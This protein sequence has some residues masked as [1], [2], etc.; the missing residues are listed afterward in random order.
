A[1]Q[2]QI[3]TLP[4]MGSKTELAI[5][6]GLEMLKEM[7]GQV[8]LG[9]A[10]PL[11]LLLQQQILAIP[12]VEQ[13]E[14][15]GSVRRG[16]EMVGDVDLVV[17]VQPD[18]QVTAVMTRHPQVKKVLASEPDRLVLLTYLGVKIEIIMVKPEDF[19]ATLFYATGARAH[20]RRLL[21]L[22]AIRGLEPA[23]LGLTTANWLTAAAEVQ[24][25]LAGEESP[26]DAEP[27]QEG[28]QDYKTE[29]ANSRPLGLPAAPPECSCGRLDARLPGGLSEAEQEEAVF[30]KRLGLPYIVPELREDRGELA[31]ALR[32][33][34]PRLITLDD[35]RGDLHLHS[36]YSDGVDTIAALAAAARRRGYS[37][38]AITDHSRSL[39]IA[40][41]LSGEKI[42]RQR[43]EIDRLNERLEG[44]RVL[45]GIEVDIL[46]DGRLDY[47]DETLRQFDLVIASVHSAFRQPEEQMMARLEAAL[48]HPYVDILGHP[49]GRMLGRRQPYA[50]DV[51]RI[52]ELAAET[53]TI[54]E[55]NASPD[56]LDLN[57]VAV[58]LAKKRGVPIAIN[59]DAHDSRRLADMEYGLLTARRGWL[60]PQDVVNTW[61][62]KRLLARLKRNRKQ[63]GNK[64][65]AKLE[66]A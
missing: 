45:A 34:L 33:E 55:I 14:P 56:R 12:G 18:N 51:N 22:A 46:P 57:D 11:A 15:A 59:T 63:E 27:E 62:L 53:G 64:R 25:E 19:G 24:A 4:G 52:I 61:E 49:T 38:L 31:A 1:R 48:R 32:G 28:L 17:A 40:R 21:R 66:Q 39:V 29:Q 8:T 3:R 23:A 6:R 20:R 44:I 41:G 2:R 10:R 16:K 26:Q 43:E 54:L 37:Y 58:R 60:E 65:I 5:L 47:D 36:N 9:I 50:A 30:Y 13:A 35:I 7:Q 42:K